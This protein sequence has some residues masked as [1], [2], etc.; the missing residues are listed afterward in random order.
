MIMN[1]ITAS[2]RTKKGACYPYQMLVSSY[3]FENS[4]AVPLRFGTGL[5]GQVLRPFV[6]FS[7]PAKH[8]SLEK[9]IDENPVLGESHT[10]A[11]DTVK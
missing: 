11:A 1:C 7:R 2:C 10:N 4:E 6:Y 9:F 8:L 5:V 3:L